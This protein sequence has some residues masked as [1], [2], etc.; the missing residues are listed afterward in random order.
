ML[1]L[2]VGGKCGEQGRHLA[3]WNPEFIF[4][5]QAV[6]ERNGLCVDVLVW[7]YGSCGDLFDGKGWRWTGVQS[8][9]GRF[10][11]AW[12]AQ[13]NEWRLC[14]LLFSLYCCR[15]RL[16]DVYQ[17]SRDGQNKFSRPMQLASSHCFRSTATATVTSVPNGAP[18]M[19]HET[20]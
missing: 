11:V 9:T 7:P 12:I 8:V 4:Q 10:F 17:D 19:Q 14:C 3:D 16:G 2:C 18:I 20:W 1:V 13:T 5:L 15:R 6:G